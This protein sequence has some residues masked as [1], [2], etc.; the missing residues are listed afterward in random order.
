MIIGDG[1]SQFPSDLVEETRARIRSEALADATVTPQPPSMVA[2]L[3]QFPSD[4]VEQTRARIRS[5]SR[6]QRE[7]IE[8]DI[9]L[10]L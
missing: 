5:E 2:G 7:A 4:L 10:Y 6:I 3:A 1:P 9:K 8:R